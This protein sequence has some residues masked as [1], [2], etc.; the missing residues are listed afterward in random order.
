MMSKTKTL[1]VIGGLGPLAT[2]YFLELFTKINDVETDQQ[3]PDSIVISRP[4]TPDR[5]AYLLGKCE[6]SPL[7]FLQKTAK[8]LEMLECCC[9]A[10]PCITAHSFHEEI[11]SRISIP[12]LNIVEETALQLSEAG[13]KTAGIMA[14]D[15]TIKTQLFQKALEKH[16]IKAV[17]PDEREQSY[18][19]SVIYD[20]VKTGIAPNMEKFGA[21]AYNLRSKGA[22]CNIL[23]CTELSLVKR[24]NVIGAGYIDAMEALARKSLLMCGGAIKD[25]YKRLAT[26]LC[27]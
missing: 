4:Q 20:D 26:I 13:V 23:G 7:P 27:E 14:T 16:G 11:Q 6:D 15:G 17:V 24:G 12:L 2:A 10:M 21:A 1:G 5:T 3:H 18:V 9:L 19:M 22:Q 25:G 8:Q